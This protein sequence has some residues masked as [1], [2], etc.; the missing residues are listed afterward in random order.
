MRD[1]NDRMQQWLR[2]HGINA[3]VKYIRGGSLKGTW[4]LYEPMTRW[5]EELAAKLN[6][7]GF[8]DFNGRPLGQYSGNAGLFSVFVR[9]HKEMAEGD[10]MA[11]VSMNKIAGELVRIARELNAGGWGRFSK[12][13]SDILEAQIMIN[14]RKSESEIF[15]IIKGQLRND[16]PLMEMMREEHMTDSDL[17]EMIRSNLRFMV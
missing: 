15:N 6:G 14:K 10:I 8:T 9:G 3:R 13:L 4:R 2:A 16:R 5:S 11:T 12:D 1:E 7:L 17:R